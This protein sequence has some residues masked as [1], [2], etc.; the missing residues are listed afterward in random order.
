MTIFEGNRA[1]L[2]AFRAGDRQ[3]LTEVYWHYVAAVE[4]ILRR[5]FVSGGVTVPGLPDADVR[6]VIQE[7]FARAFSAT[8]RQR[9]DGL[10]PF[11]N[12]LMRIVRNLL[13][14]RARL[15]GRVELDPDIGDEP[16]ED[17][18][19]EEEMARGRLAEA[20]HAFV[21]GLD[22]EQRELVRLR[23]EEEQSQDAVAATMGVSRRRVRT[24]EKR[25][26][27]GLARHL[28]DAGLA[29]EL[30]HEDQPQPKR[31]SEGRSS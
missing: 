1:L 6:D 15:A 11:R 13:V 9:Y 16:G 29:G 12:Y 25:V 18:D 31:P 17:E 5:G 22:P 27:E 21:Q 26:R 8:A 23:F 4:R 30:A 28:A 20:T 7:A 24:L 14:D 10:R 3:A 2:L 19:A